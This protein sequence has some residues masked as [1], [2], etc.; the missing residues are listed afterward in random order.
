MEMRTRTLTPPPPAP[1][2]AATPASA[3]GVREPVPVPVVAVEPETG[4]EA[5]A[6]ASATASA[7]ATASAS[8]RAMVRRPSTR[9]PPRSPAPPPGRRRR[10]PRLALA[11]RLVAGVPR[12]RRGVPQGV[13]RLADE[14]EQPL[15]VPPEEVGVRPRRDARLRGGLIRVEPKRR[16][17]V[18]LPNVPVTQRRRRRDAGIRG[19]REEGLV[20]AQ[21][22][23]EVGGVFRSPASV[24]ARRASRRRDA[25]EKSAADRSA[26][27]LVV[28]PLAIIPPAAA[29]ANAVGS[30]S[31]LASA[32]RSASR[33]RKASA[34]IRSSRWICARRETDFR[35]AGLVASARPQSA[36]ASRYRPSACAA[37]ARLQK[38]VAANAP[39][40]AP[41]S[42]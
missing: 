33:S 18:R 21:R 10:R 38:H 19:I 42:K 29:S 23:D 5:E 32:S 35:R 27:P 14:L 20:E 11:P 2:A 8:A 6:T 40:S 17:A 25:D 31:R 12:A 36:S 26:D 39:A 15:G 9:P 4:A 16:R 34:G 41:K 22:G 24:A 1:A 7:T 13:P 3:R 37:A 30:R 28:P